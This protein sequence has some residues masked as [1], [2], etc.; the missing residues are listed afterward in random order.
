MPLSDTEFAA[1][2]QDTKTI[3]QDILW[4]GDEDNS[5]AVQFRAEVA[6]NGGW[7]LFVQGWYNRRT[8]NLTYALI[9]RTE[10]RISGL[11]M[12]KDHHNPQCNQVGQKHMHSWTEQYRDKEAG[13][14]DAI[15]A[16]ATDPR[17]VWRQFCAMVNIRH[18]GRM[19]LPPA[20]H[21]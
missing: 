1:I 8:S 19:S 7:L 4:L 5:P 13:V 18:Q 14:P 2:I 17:E 15:S 16:P 3:A 20:W 9:L 10:G 11:C 6:S 21:R 12:G